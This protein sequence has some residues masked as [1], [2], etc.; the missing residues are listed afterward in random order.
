MVL[1]LLEQFPSRLRSGE[2]G[3]DQ[4]GRGTSTQ[5]GATRYISTGRL[6]GSGGFSGAMVTFRQTFIRQVAFL[7]TF[8]GPDPAKDPENRIRSTRCPNLTRIAVDSKFPEGYRD[9]QPPEGPDQ[10]ARKQ[11]EQC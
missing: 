1:C 11:E 7:Q 10:K 9:Y 8:I 3:N 2:P 5:E 4:V 6:A